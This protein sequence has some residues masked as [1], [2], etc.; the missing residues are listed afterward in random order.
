MKPKTV[1]TIVICAVLACLS[2]VILVFYN[3]NMKAIIHKLKVIIE[4]TKAQNAVVT[5]AIF[6]LLQLPHYIFFFP[7]TT[8]FYIVTAY[9]YRDFWYVFGLLLLSTITWILIIYHIY[10]LIRQ[11]IVDVIK[12]E[13]TYQ[14]LENRAKNSPWQTSL[15]VRFLY[16][17]QIYKNIILVV[18]NVGMPVFVVSE[19]AHL[20]PYLIIVILIGM[21]ISKVEDFYNGKVDLADPKIKYLIA[22]FSFGLVLSI[23]VFVVVAY[24]AYRQYYVWK[25]DLTK[26][27]EEEPVN[28]E[29]KG[30]VELGLNR[31]L[32]SI[33]E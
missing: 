28:L 11:R 15:M 25:T 9:L 33:K 12:E 22:A 29:T 26:Q 23:A 27:L 17:P 18:L 24:S 10:G 5:L 21:S 20:V 16:L 14:V 31:D 2:I 13:A 8:L 7:G 6:M 30:A 4:F 19:L 32:E 3:R 1:W